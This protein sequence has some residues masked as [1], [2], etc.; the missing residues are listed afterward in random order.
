MD[1]LKFELKKLFLNRVNL[2]AIG[3]LFAVTF[4]INLNSTLDL[5]KKVGGEA[6]LFEIYR[7][8]E[9]AIN[10][11]AAAEAKVMADRM[12]EDPSFA[13]SVDPAKQNFYYRYNYTA[14]YFNLYTFGRSS[15]DTHLAE[16]PEHPRSLRGIQVKM[17]SLAEKGEQDT[18]KY[19]SLVNQ[20]ARMAA[21]G[22][23]GFYYNN[24]WWGLFSYLNGGGSFSF[25]AVLVPLALASVFSREYASGM[26]SVIFSSRHGRKK[27]GRGKMLAAAIYIVT[28]VLIYNGLQLVAFIG[29]GTVRGWDKPLN[30][31]WSFVFTPFAL[32][33]LQF[34]VLQLGMQLFGYLAIGLF[35]LYL[36]SRTAHALYAFFGGML[37]AF[38]PSIIGMLTDKKE[39][40]RPLV[41]LSAGRMAKAYQAIIF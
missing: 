3:I 6:R 10:E 19:R 11:A 17:Q 1:I 9:G 26:D 22:K 33:N 13:D 30:S 40:L 31:I 2:V 18:Y 21:V 14:M 37:F 38:Y 35:T 29:A 12:D 32:N 34:Y 39:W 27:L 20:Q 24:D 36:S 4:V 25:L 23:P 41:E 5:Y 15:K 8:Y 16:D 7:P 28:V